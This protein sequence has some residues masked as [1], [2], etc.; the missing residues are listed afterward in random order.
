MTNA[1]SILRFQDHLYLRQRLVLSV[2]SRKPV[3][4][5]RIRADG[6]EPGLR[7][8]EISFLRLLE[9][10]TNGT[11]VS[12]S[13]T[14]TSLLFVPGILIG[15]QCSH[16]C[17]TSRAI[18]YFLEPVIALAPFSKKPIALT[19]TGITSDDHSLGADTIRTVMLPFLRNWGLEDGVELKIVKRGAPPLGGGE[20]RFVCPPVKALRTVQLTDPGRIKRIRGIASSTR[21]SPVMANRL[22]EAAR[23]FLTYYIPD[24]YIY[25]DVYKGANSGLSPG[26]ALSL[27]A[28]STTGVLYTAE[29]AALPP[30]EDRPARTDP[31]QSGGA[32]ARMLLAA[33]EAGGCVDPINMWV[34]LLFCVTCSEDVSKIRIAK[35]ADAVSSGGLPLSTVQYLRDLREFFNVTFKIKDDG[36]SL[37]LSCVGVGYSNTNKKAQ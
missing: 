2:L 9:R 10:L 30:T 14:G 31:E 3:R 23:S 19:L 1:S 17:P 7:D 11:T 13:H 36:A 8:F 35:S 27:V 16:E 4:I 28:E 34:A 37:F 5:D 33:I 20:V 32:C 26:F 15:G 12:I 6:D 18:G 25:S 24:V 22:I 21:T 29:V